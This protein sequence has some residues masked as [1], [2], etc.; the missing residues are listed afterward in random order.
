MVIWKV[1]GDAKVGDA[2]NGGDIASSEIDD[3]KRPTLVLVV[4]DGAASCLWC[5]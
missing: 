5:A 3:L 1:G 4:K 2:F